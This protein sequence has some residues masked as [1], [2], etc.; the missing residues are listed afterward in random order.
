MESHVNK[1]K[2]RTEISFL[3]K[4]FLFFINCKSHFLRAVFCSKKSEEKNHGIIYSNK[5]NILQLAVLKD[6][7]PNFYNSHKNVILDRI[8]PD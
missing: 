6:E 2:S 7:V 3:F 1:Y 8:P 5:A 4:S